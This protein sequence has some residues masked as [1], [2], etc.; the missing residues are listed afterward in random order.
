[1]Y[2]GKFAFQNRLG[3]LII[4]RKCTILLCFTLYLSRN[5]QVPTPQGAYI[6][7]GDVNGGFL[8]FLL[9]LGGL[10]YLEGL[11]Q[12]GAYFRNFMVS[13]KPNPIKKKTDSE[14]NVQ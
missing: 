14:Y 1:M 4:G 9:S 11:I 2:G 13:Q 8:F 10:Y 7:R 3:Q 12:G 5:F 6:Q